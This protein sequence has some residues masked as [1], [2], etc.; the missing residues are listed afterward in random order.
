MS[1]SQEIDMIEMLERLTRLETEY[2]TLEHQHGSIQTKLD[3][4]ITRFNKYE[5][6][7]GGVVMVVSA[8]VAILIAL[9]TELLKWLAGR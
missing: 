8:I 3:I 6:K 1:P 4:L 7:W 5:A 2:K 9:K